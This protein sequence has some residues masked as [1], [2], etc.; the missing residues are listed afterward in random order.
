MDT[1]MEAG[2]VWSD[3]LLAAAASCHV[4]I[5]LLSPAY[6]WRSAWCAME[7]DLFSGREVVRRT[8]G[9]ASNST[10]IVP[11]LWVPI[12][13][14]V[15]PRVERIQRF[16]PPPVPGKA[17]SLYE[18][19]GVFGLFRMGLQDEVGAVSWTLAQ[20]IVS[21]YADHRVRRKGSPDITA[22]RR[23]FDEGET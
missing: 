3:E 19:H 1:T 21:I 8:D 16:T 14:D 9:K 4:F 13:D 17:E 12:K 20:Q 22:L 5:A 7:W 6:I 15:P 2:D 11:V 18:E 23:S 10:A